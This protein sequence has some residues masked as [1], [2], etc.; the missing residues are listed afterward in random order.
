M[1]E[2]L[3]ISAL[4]ITVSIGL[5]FFLRSIQK[6]RISNRSLKDPFQIYQWKESPTLLYFW[7]HNCSQCKPQER[8]IE[9]AQLELRRSGKVLEILKYNALESTL[10]AKQLGVLTV[11][12]TVLLDKKGRV[13]A[14]NNGLIQANKIIKQ[15][16]GESR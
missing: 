7:T 6:W 12:T 8:Y 2:R 16:I 1:I 10:L 9:Q 4:I 13:V 14:W 5:G 11:P 3:Y 15:Y